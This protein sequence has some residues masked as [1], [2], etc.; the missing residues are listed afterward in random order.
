MEERTEFGPGTRPLVY[1][2]RAVD[3]PAISATF[4]E[5]RI[6]RRRPPDRARQWAAD[7]RVGIEG[8]EPTGGEPLRILIEK[9]FEC[10]DAPPGEPGRRVSQPA[11]H[12]VLAPARGGPEESCHARTRRSDPGA[13]SPRRDS[14]P[15]QYDPKRAKPFEAERPA[16]TPE[17]SKRTPT[18]ST[19]RTARFR[20]PASVT[21][22]PV[23]PRRLP[24]NALRAEGGRGRTLKS[25]LMVNQKGGFDCPSCAW[26][27]PDG[28][29]ARRRVL[30]ERRQGGG[31]RG[32][33]EARRR[34]SSS[35]STRSPSC[36]TQTDHWLE[37]Q[38]R[39]TQPMVPAPGRRRTTSRSP[40]TT[41]SR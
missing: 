22:S 5:G 8:A 21:P 31:Q 1:E 11:R 37:Q 14:A 17:V 27:D 34:P 41:P 40:G 2:V 24:V 3:G 7:D 16:V 39:L 10:L 28:D 38:G 6:T 29:R 13:E 35:R 12:E 30:R 20:R 36:A 23:A 32:D 4:E 18:R 25:L 26:P 33:D 19:R 15:D 9:D